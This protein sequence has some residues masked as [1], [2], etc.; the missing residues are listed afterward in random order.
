[1]IARVEGT[2]KFEY[3]G[4]GHRYMYGKKVRMNPP[5]GEANGIVESVEYLT[6]LLTLMIDYDLQHNHYTSSMVSVE[7]EASIFRVFHQPPRELCST[8]MIEHEKVGVEKA[9][10]M[11]PEDD[12]DFDRFDRL[13][14]KVF[15]DVD[16]NRYYKVLGIEHDD[17]VGFLASSVECDID[18]KIKR[19]CMTEY[20]DV[21]DT[22][23]TPYMLEGEFAP[24]DTVDEMILAYQN[25]KS[26]RS[27]SSSSS[28]SSSRSR[29]SRSR[30][31]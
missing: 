12:V 25:K 5:S 7:P 14:D 8:A 27:S 11:I 31:E 22:E 9:K 2:R 6:E 21:I 4:F 10:E 28:S 1:M 29:S 19:H 3:T 23:K 26:G 20:G 16:E 13:K 18:G 24:G 15:Y 30:T 17:K